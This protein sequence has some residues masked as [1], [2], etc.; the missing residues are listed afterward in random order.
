MKLI[1]ALAAFTMASLVSVAQPPKGRQ[2]NEPDGRP[3]VEEVLTDLTA[4]QRTR[5]DVITRRAKK[6]SDVYQKRLNGVA[7]SI[8]ILMDEG[9]DNSAKLFPLFEQEGRLQAEINKIF[10]RARL[11]MDAILTPEQ[12]N[13]IKTYRENSQKQRRRPPQ[14]QGPQPPP[15]YQPQKR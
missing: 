8:R 1:V 3:R 6:E 11:E 7:D 14:S 2:V 15:S 9:K 4:T 10:Y 5:I 12:I 13:A